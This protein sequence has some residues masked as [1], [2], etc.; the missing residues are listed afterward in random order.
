M[1]KSFGGV[2]VLKY[3]FLV[4]VYNVEK[5]LEQCI[6]SMLAQ[7]YR[8]FEIILVD[9]GS[10]DN[11][12]RICDDYAKKYP[13]VIKVIHKQNEGLVSAREAGI[14]NAGGDV[15]LFVDSDDFVEN[16]LLESVDNE[17]LKDSELDMVIYSFCYFS[18][19]VKT[20]RKKTLSESEIVFEGESKKILYKTLMLTPLITSLWTKAVRTEV[21]KNDIVDYSQYYCHSMGEDQFRSISLFSIA[22][23]IKY[24]NKDFYN[25]RTDNFSISREFSV[26]SIS[27]KNTMY[28]YNRF[29]KMLPEWGMDNKETV[30]RLQAAWLNYAVY[31]F[32]Q[33][34]KSAMSYSQRKAIVDFDWKTMFP[35]GATESKYNSD[36]T[37]KTYNLIEKKKYMHL[38]FLYI[39]NNYYKIIKKF[40]RK[41]L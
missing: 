40:L 34:Y 16:D 22:K 15:C 33:Y 11:S 32:N 9:D 8:N 24:I 39:K 14:A 1:E 31:T 35:E 36:I 6:E 41:K 27:K 12:G 10:T 23:K 17:F 5:Y 19:G 2:I 29:F 21:L 28:I 25:Y 37:L 18:D 20:K 4:P 30:E 38:Y 13:D 3:S 26:E 7:T